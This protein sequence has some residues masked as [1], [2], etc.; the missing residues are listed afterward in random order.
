MPW[1]PGPDF[2]VRVQNDTDLLSPTKNKQ[3]TPSS[4][5]NPPPK[6]QTTPN[7]LPLAP[8]PSEH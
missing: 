5:H 4:P 2:E 3:K 1:I 7:K 6:K 8:L